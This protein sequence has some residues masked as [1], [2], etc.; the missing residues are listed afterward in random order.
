MLLY[1]YMFMYRNIYGASNFK[2]KR[3]S[4]LSF[5]TCSEFRWISL[6]DIL[7]FKKPT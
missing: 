2:L 3:I 4:E 5:D 1:M 6:V 7:E